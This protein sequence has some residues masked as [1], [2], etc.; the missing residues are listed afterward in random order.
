[1]SSILQL[2][3]LRVII[4]YNC[5]RRQIE[6]LSSYLYFHDHQVI[7]IHTFDSIR[8]YSSVISLLFNRHNFINL[9]SCRFVAN[10]SSMKLESVIKQ[11]KN[12]NKLASFTIIQR[13]DA[14]SL[15]E[16]DLTRLMLMHKSSSLHS[17]GL[18]YP[19]DYL[20]I[21]NYTSIPSNLT[22]LKLTIAGLPSTISIY[23]ILPILRLCHTVRHLKIFIK[24]TEFHNNNTIK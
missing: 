7:S 11:I 19:Y 16:N 10:K 4:G 21:S 6:F 5:V 23:S 13:P 9:Q 3:P 1:M 22:S 20:D 24:H 15:N 2:I 14:K 12:L 17:L 18:Q 8:D